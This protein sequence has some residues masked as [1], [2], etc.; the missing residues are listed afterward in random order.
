VARHLSVEKRHRQSEAR[1]R[2]NRAV[3]TRIRSA[4]KEFAAAGTPEARQEALRQAASVADKAAVK[5]V[6][7]KNKAARLKSRL[8]RKVSAASATPSTP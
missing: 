3:K 7:H 8:A 4:V 6:I 2:R 5:R 1:N